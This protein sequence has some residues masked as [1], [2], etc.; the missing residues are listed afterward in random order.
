ME[1]KDIVLM[2]MLGAMLLLSILLMVWNLVSPLVRYSRRKVIILRMNNGYIRDILE[3]NG[4]IL[5]QRV[6]DD[7]I[8]VLYSLDGKTIM[9]CTGD[10]ELASLKRSRW[11]VVDCGMSLSF[12]VYEMHKMA[13][14]RRG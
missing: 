8:T 1:T 10:R 9:G 11:Q 3:G 12:F 7:G 13:W 4:F 5:D 6:M 14:R 2:A